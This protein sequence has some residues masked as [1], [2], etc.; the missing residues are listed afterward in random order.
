MPLSEADWEKEERI[1]VD[2][3]KLKLAIDEANSEQIDQDDMN[4][5]RSQAVFN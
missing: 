3:D 1:P 2:H 5:A 4:R